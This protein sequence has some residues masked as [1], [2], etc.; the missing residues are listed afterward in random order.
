MMKRCM[1]SSC[2]GATM[3]ITRRRRKLK[4]QSPRLPNWNLRSVRTRPRAASS[5]PPSS[6]LRR[7]LLLTKRPWLRLRRSAKSRRLNL[8][9]L[10]RTT[11]RHWRTSRQRSRC[12]PGTTAPPS[13]SLR[14]PSLRMGTRTCHGA[15]SMNREQSGTSTISSRS[16]ACMAT[17][18]ALLHLTT[19]CSKKRP[20]RQ[21]HLLHSRRIGRLARWLWSS[22]VCRPP[23]LSCS[24]VM[25]TCHLTLPRAERSWEF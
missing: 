24:V 17:F 2:A 20:S 15:V 22:V 7:T 1:N 21:W 3:V 9:S 10:R 14:S 5:A 4:L 13:L 25:A 19:S 16:L 23:P 12:S 8:Q 6:L 11:S 18:L